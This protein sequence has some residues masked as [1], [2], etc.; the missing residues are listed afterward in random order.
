MIKFK[1]NGRGM[2]TKVAKEVTILYMEEYGREL[3]VFFDIASWS[4]KKDDFIYTDPQFLI[5]LKA[6]LKREGKKYANAIDYSEHGMQG[7]DYVSFD[8]P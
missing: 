1:T 5:E 8:L 7:I 6:H 3:R 2:W 4:N